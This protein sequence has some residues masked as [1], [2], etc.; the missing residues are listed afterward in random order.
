MLIGSDWMLFRIISD[1]FQTGY[2]I[3]LYV[4]QSDD[5]PLVISFEGATGWWQRRGSRHPS[6][7]SR[8]N[9]D[10]RSD[11]PSG[12]P[13]WLWKIAIEIVSFPS[14]NVDFP[15]LPYCTRG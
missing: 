6:G 1:M 15:F 4:A 5:P 3:C 13:T 2:Y 12:K 11:I 9:G 8:S 7:A 10:F 14:R